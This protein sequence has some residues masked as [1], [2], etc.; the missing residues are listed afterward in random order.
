MKSLQIRA[1]FL[2]VH[3]ED[4]KRLGYAHAHVGLT[5][6]Q[7]QLACLTAKLIVTIQRII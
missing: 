3:H 2:S 6:R 7:I 5:L 4:N 1:K